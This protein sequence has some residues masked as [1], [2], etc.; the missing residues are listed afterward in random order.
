MLLNDEMINAVGPSIVNPFDPALINPNSLDVRLG[1]VFKI[2]RQFPIA[3]TGLRPC[4][5]VDLQHDDTDD[6][7]DVVTLA[8]I[9]DAFTIW[10]GQR[11][12]AETLET[13][14]IPADLGAQ[15]EWKSSYAR[16]FLTTHQ[17]GGYIDAGF[18]GTVTLELINHSPWGIVL[19][20]GM[21]IAQLSLIT[22]SAPARR[23]YVHP[24]LGSHYHGQRGAQAAV[25]RRV[26]EDVLAA[27]QMVNAKTGL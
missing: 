13:F 14:S 6:L 19:R 9:G 20:Y 1:G 18:T 8:Q 22:L 5:V 23:P 4:H 7:F 11:V 3:Y 16:L 17:T 25:R 24:L 10:P 21:R 15:L 12:L 27:G 26:G 2:A